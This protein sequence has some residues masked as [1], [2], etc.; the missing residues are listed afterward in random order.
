M[1]IKLINCLGLM[2][3]ESS[4]NAFKNQ[5]SVVDRKLNLLS[6]INQKM[7][8]ADVKDLDNFRKF[9]DT[10]SRIEKEIRNI[11]LPNL[12]RIAQKEVVSEASGKDRDN[13]IKVL[14]DRLKEASELEGEPK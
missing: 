12:E 9:L 2:G 14:K 6:D 3:C 5:Y 13:V 1:Q 4:Q 10:K 11:D 8:G 7:K